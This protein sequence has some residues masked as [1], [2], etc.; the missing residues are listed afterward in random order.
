MI[1]SILVLSLAGEDLSFAERV[2]AGPVVRFSRFVVL[3]ALVSIPRADRFG[4][5]ADSRWIPITAL[6]FGEACR[7]SRCTAP[8][9]S[10]R[11][12]SLGVTAMAG[13]VHFEVGMG[14]SIRSTP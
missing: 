6:A 12:A 11:F 5:R 3:P 8:F 13:L 2:F 7:S 9:R 14:I 10:S 4:W 1:T